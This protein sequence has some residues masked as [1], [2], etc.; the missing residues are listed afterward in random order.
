MDFEQ[1]QVMSPPAKSA[2]PLLVGSGVDT[3]V[4]NVRY[5]DSSYEPVK[6]ELDK[7]LQQRLDGLQQQARFEE[8]ALATDWVFQNTLLFLEPHGAGKQWRWLLTCRYLSIAISRGKFNDLIAQVRFAS[9]YLWLEEWVGS[10]L[11]HVHAL[12]M[13]IFGEQINLQVSELHLCADIAGFDFSQVDYQEHFVTRVRK[14]DAIYA[15]G[16]D[17]VSL[18][19][20]KVATLRFSSHAAPL[21][22]TIY[23]K[24]LEIEQKSHKTWFYDLWRRHGWDGESCVWRVEFRFKRQFFRN[25]ESPIE[26]AYDVLGELKPLWDYAV[27]HVAGGA[28]GL[29]DGWLRYVVPSDDSNRSRWSVHPVWSVVQTAFMEPG[30]PGLGSIV[31]QRVREVNLE[32]GL[33]AIIGY[34]STLAAWLGDEYVVPETDM[35]LVLQWLYE[36]GLTYLASK[37]RD[38]FLEVVKKQLRYKE[39]LNEQQRA[40][41]DAA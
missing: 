4:L 41:I 5:A 40:A 35:S 18:D 34:A 15:V 2:V 16:V 29:P 17:G 3:L 6:Q 7:D 25:L 22:C 13:M 9:E 27:G 37:Q 23:N 32:R 26:G 24:G 12:L 36:H 20:H 28:D 10:A 39:V 30:E 11:Y 38:F 1:Q 21:S 14:N 19:C 33:A 31:R 8:Q